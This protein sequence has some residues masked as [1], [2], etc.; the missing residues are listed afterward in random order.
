MVSGERA[1]VL[2]ADSEGVREMDERSRRLGRR[3]FLIGAAVTAGSAILAACGGSTAT[4]TP[5]PVATTGSTAPTAASGSAPAATT[6][7][8]AASS[9][10][11]SAPAPTTA[12]SAAVSS[13]AAAASPAASGTTAAGATAAPAGGKT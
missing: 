9:A 12:G 6:A 10:A 1:F 4:D 5:K 11:T 3:Q 13:P 2:T 7:P 8:T